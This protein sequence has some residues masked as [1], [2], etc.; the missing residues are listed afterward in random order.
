MKVHLFLM[1]FTMLILAACGPQPEAPAQAPIINATVERVTAAPRSTPE[2]TASAAPQSS[3]QPTASPV[4]PNEPAVEIDP[5]ILA[6]QLVEQT[7]LPAEESWQMMPCDGEAAFFC[8]SEDEAIL[9]FAELLIFPLSGYV[10]DH[11]VLQAA[12]TLS[13]DNQALSDEQ[14]AVVQEALVGLADEY[15]AIF[16]A[17]RVITYPNDLFTPLEF[18]PG[19]MG[20]LPALA[21][22]FVHTSPEGEVLERYLNIAAFDREV[23]YW[24]V[25]N[26]DPAN[27][28][29]FVSDTAMTQFIP[30]FYEIAANLPIHTATMP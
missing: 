29:T 23:I 18:E 8:I 12:E 9:G 10:D 16:S 5:F 25:I 30:T 4:P 15:L 17:D 26:Y 11:V 1:L 13:L 24:M 19:R 21:F 22:G 6:R 7:T 28:S 20:S 2:S 27:I 14:Q 3:L